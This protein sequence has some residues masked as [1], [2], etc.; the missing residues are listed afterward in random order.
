MTKIFWGRWKSV[1]FVQNKEAFSPENINCTFELFFK[2]IEFLPNGACTSV[3]GNKTISGREMQEWTNGF[4]LHKWDCTACAYEI[5]NI[6]NTEYLFI[7]WKSGDYRWGG[8]D[9]NF[10]VLTRM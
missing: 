9:P 5:R 7:E 10:Y 2:E 8:F 1:A 4:I 6:G 3:Y